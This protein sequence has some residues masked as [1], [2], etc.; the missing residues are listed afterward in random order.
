M[1]IPALYTVFKGGSTKIGPVIHTDGKMILDAKLQAAREMFA[2]SD[3]RTEVIV[4]DVKGLNRGNMD[5]NLLTEVTIPGSDIWYLTHIEDIEDIF[6]GFMGDVMKIMIPY[7]TVRNKMVLEEAYDVSDNCIP[8]VFSSVYDLNGM[9]S[10]IENVF[11]I[12]YTEV[13]VFDIDDVVSEGDWTT[14]T[15]RFDNVIPYVRNRS[16]IEML[17]SLGFARMIIDHQF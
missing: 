4:V 9:I 16:R 1:E 5:D 10:C 7:H 14:L 13:V 17:R 15:R 8:V 12:G 3:E 6:D 11:R 2:E